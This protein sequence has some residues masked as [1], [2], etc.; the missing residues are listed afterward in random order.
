[1]IQRAGRHVAR[2]WY[3]GVGVR[4][5]ILGG[6]AILLAGSILAGTVAAERYGPNVDGWAP[7]TV[8]APTM[9]PSSAA[10][11]AT[12]ATTTP[13]TAPTLP[14]ASAPSGPPGPPGQPGPPGPPGQV[15]TV[16]VTVPGPT[17]PPSTVGVTTTVTATT[18]RPCVT[19]PSASRPK[20]TTQQKPCLPR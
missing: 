19:P 15:V 16:T 14:P 9:T 20:P 17:A 12:T 6:S 7:T 2:R 3:T 8:T 11:T 5:V 18:S 13:A 10:T 4:E 1:M